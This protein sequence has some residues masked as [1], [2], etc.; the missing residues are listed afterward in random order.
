MERNILRN[1]SGLTL[2]GVIVAMTIFT[3]VM[4]VGFSF[5]VIGN[6]NI[7]KAER[8][9]IALHLA[10]ARL[11]ILKATPFDLIL[12]NTETSITIGSGDYETETIVTDITSY[13]EIQ[14]TV[15][16]NNGE[17]ELFTII[18]DK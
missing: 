2:V 7:I 4:V 6:E 18:A 15:T 14:L 9:K 12:D 11:E 1:N 5:F 13:K 8:K 16:W 10:S 17:V 3:V